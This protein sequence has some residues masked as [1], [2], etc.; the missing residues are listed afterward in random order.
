MSTTLETL[1]IEVLRLPPAD[2]SRLLD[3]LIESLDDET[4]VDKAWD[5]EAARRDAEID[6][7]T[8][9]PVDGKEVLARL[10]AQVR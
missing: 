6:N 10:R 8:A 4:A 9:L 7:G 3:R 1:E 2:R 5:D